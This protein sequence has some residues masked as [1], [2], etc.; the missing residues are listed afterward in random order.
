MAGVLSTRKA[1]VGPGRG[2]WKAAGR[3]SLYHATWDREKI[4][5]TQ[6]AQFRPLLGPYFSLAFKASYTLASVSISFSE[7]IST[8]AA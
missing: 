8:D 3:S 6:E 2:R 5:A 1:R 4:Q 7:W